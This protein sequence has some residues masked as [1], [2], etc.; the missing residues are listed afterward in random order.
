M[1]GILDSTNQQIYY[2]AS[3]DSDLYSSN[4]DELSLM[5][6][7]SPTNVSLLIETMEY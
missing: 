1:G 6:T 5:V 7:G 2:D 3:V 4:D